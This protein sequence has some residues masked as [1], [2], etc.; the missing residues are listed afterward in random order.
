MKKIAIVTGANTG[1]GYATALALAKKKY[2]VVMICRSLDRAREAQEKLIAETGNPDIVFFLMDLASLENVRKVAAK[3]RVSYPKIDVLINNAGVMT[4]K[5]EETVEGF[6]KMLGVNHLGPFLFTCLLLPSLERAVQGR[7]VMVASGAYKFGARQFPDPEADIHF[8]AMTAY[9]RSKLANILFTEALAK[10]IERTKVTI[11]ALHPGAV[12]TDLGIN[13]ETGFGKALVKGL[14]PFFRSAEKGAQ[15][16]VYLAD[17]AEVAQV[18]GQYFVNEKPEKVKSFATDATLISEVWQ[19][20]LRW[21]Q[22]EELEDP[23]I[24]G[25][26]QAEL[27]DEA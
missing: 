14:Q 7:I 27:I 22:L 2:H 15:T 3:L 25:V 11:N 9:G 18:S 20:S 4:I 6:E 12:S 21:T 1:M 10:K 19:K 26:S 13:R 16:A 8:S 5:R 17:S 24:Y 23:M